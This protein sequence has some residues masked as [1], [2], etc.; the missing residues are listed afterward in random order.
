MITTLAVVSGLLQALGYTV[1]IWKSL[2]KEVNPNPTTWLMFGYG[3]A[4]LT[5]LEWDRNAR[6][7]L[8]VL[9]II[10]AVLSV[11]VAAICYFRG[12]LRWPNEP[13]SRA[14]FG[15]DIAL[16][17]GYVSVGLASLL[18]F[19]SEDERKLLALTFLI[20]SNASTVV[21]FVPIVKETWDDPSQE[22]PLAWTIWTL[23]YA[24]LGYVTFREEGAWTEFMIYPISCALLHGLVGALAFRAHLRSRSVN[25]ALAE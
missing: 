4:L 6:W 12:T 3:T 9:P 20:L 19:V 25:S 10:C 18:S 17:V 7:E 16:T 2:R 15:T 21:S 13:Y 8:L 11:A 22:H 5:V 14:A 23:A 1:Y 24:T